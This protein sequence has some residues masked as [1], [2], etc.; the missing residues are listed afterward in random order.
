MELVNLSIS[1]STHIFLGIFTNQ[2]YKISVKLWFAQSI[3]LSILN[4]TYGFS[5]A[6]W[7][8]IAGLLEGLGN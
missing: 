3:N 2:R 8:S 7:K 5:L 4:G 6:D 1:I